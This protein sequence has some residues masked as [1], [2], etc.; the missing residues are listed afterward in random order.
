MLISALRSK[1]N[2]LV[3]TAVLLLTV[4]C[5][6]P[7]SKS[8]RK[9]LDPNLTFQALRERPDA[10]E[11]EWVLLGGTIIETRNKQEGTVI[12]VLQKRLNRRGE[13]KEEDDTEGR[14]LVFADRFLDPVVYNEGRKI[15]IA[16]TVEGGHVEKI[17]EVDYVYP[18]LRAREIHLWKARPNAIFVY[19]YPVWYR[20]ELD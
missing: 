11:G 16:G 8:V 14:F 19:P 2:T 17:G 3:S 9:E 7:V 20:W 5:P 10:H 18:V 15:T 6:S 12:E 4:G 1:R 13:P